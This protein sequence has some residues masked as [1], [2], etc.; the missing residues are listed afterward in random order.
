MLGLDENLQGQ[1]RYGWMPNPQAV[2]IVQ[3]SLPKPLFGSDSDGL[4]LLRDLDETKEMLLYDSFRKIVGKD[5]PKGPQGIGDCV[6]W[7]YANFE[8]YLQIAQMIDQIAKVNPHLAQMLLYEVKAAWSP[9]LHD[10]IKG[11]EEGTLKV[12]R[13]AS[14]AELDGDDE[15]VDRM[16]SVGK[17]EYQEI[18][19]ESIY[20][21]S[22]VEIGG[23]HNSYSD[24][25]VGAWAA[26]AIN[27]Y[28]SL[29]RKELE[30]AG[31][32]GNYDA[33]RAKEWGAKGL[34]DSLEPISKKHLVKVVSMI[35]SF[36]EAAAAIQNLQPVP[37]CSDQGF[38]MTRDNQG[39]CR[40]QGTWYHCMDFIGVRW[41]RPGLLLSQSWGPNTPTGPVYKDQPDNCFWVDAATVDRMLRQEDSYTGNTYDAYAKRDYVSYAH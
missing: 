7:G 12:K 15:F 35:K 22:R 23:Q 21:L 29:S 17:F 30:A 16:M 4:G 33:R 20:A 5:A 26:K 10:T 3:K 41:D 38:S 14:I 32:S 2:E 6:S 28:G 11:L 36:K 9:E 1:G 34:P 24:G 19:T 31:L 37:V 27:T 18:A 39:F 13:E 25:S 8:N 40:P